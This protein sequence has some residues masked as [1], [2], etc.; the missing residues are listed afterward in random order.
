M[1][2]YKKKY[3]AAKFISQLF[4][5]QDGQ[6]FAIMKRT[7]QPKINIEPEP[8]DWAI[9][10]IGIIAIILLSG[11][12]MYYFDSLPDEIPSHFDISGNP[13]GYSGKGI[14]WLLPA[15][16]LVMYVGL[17]FLNRYPHIFNYLITI[18]QENALRQYKLATR[19]IRLLNT[20]VACL[21]CYIT[22]ATIQTAIGSQSGLGNYSVVF[23]LVS[24]FGVIGI[25][26]YKSIKYK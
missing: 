23:F 5:I 3:I 26:F 16:G 21:F 20:I 12:P 11:L 10:L 25:Y 19:F 13:D 24:I 9:E 17:Y 7:T 22:Y 1:D 14:I 15:V 8:I 6:E 2:E 18:T 4:H